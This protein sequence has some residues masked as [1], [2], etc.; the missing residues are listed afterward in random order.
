MGK[1]IVGFWNRFTYFLQHSAA[2][3]LWLLS[4]AIIVLMIVTA[5]FVLLTVYLRIRH[6]MTDK[7]V[8]HLEKTWRPAL[9]DVLAG[10]QAPTH[11]WQRVAKYDGLFFMEFLLKYALRFKG[12]ERK[13]LCQLAAPYLKQAEK[14][15]HSWM[16]EQRAHAIQILSLLGLQSHAHVVIRGLSDRSPIVSMVA[17]RALT[18]SGQVEYAQ[19]VMAQLYRFD[20]WNIHFLSSMLAA[21]GAVI[22]PQL[23]QLF[24]DPQQPVL[25]RTVA[26]DTLLKTHDLK[27]ADDAV[28]VLAQEPHQ[29]LQAA[30][31]RLL[32]AVGRSEHITVIRQW[33]FARDFFIR[34]HAVSALGR[35]GSESEIPYLR[36]A[37]ED[38]SPWVAFHAA[39]S[40]KK[41]SGTEILEQ[42]IQSAH[43][44]A[45]IAEQVLLAS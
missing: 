40:L 34:A 9:M 15:S 6:F 19:A 32:G 16:P 35:L 44:R 18:K 38:P 21:V 11:L 2:H 36:K 12:Q 31:L 33:C 20:T 5:V 27:A 28:K 41:L 8:R 26:A 3:L 29:E 7:H 17:A 22:A 24:L 4:I 45:M 1:G 25:S 37:F 10:D 30:A 13:L 39:T 14:V 42:I 23:R 43:P